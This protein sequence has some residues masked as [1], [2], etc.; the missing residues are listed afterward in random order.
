MKESHPLE[1]QFV[2]FGYT[3][4]DDPDMGEGSALA[5]FEVRAP[6]LVEIYHPMSELWAEAAGMGRRQ[7]EELL[8][9]LQ[10][11]SMTTV[12]SIVHSKDPYQEF[13][14]ISY[15]WF[16]ME[17]RPKKVTNKWGGVFTHTKG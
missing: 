7:L 12:H 13:M 6:R 9:I 8:G 2:V 17:A 4:Q 15:K 11:T 1:G 16:S 14:G 5:L 10:R 3:Q